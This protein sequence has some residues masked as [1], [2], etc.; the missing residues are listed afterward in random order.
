M[1]GRCCKPDSL[2]DHLHHKRARK[3]RTKRFVDNCKFC[4]S[5]A[6]LDD[7]L[8]EERLEALGHFTLLHGGNVLDGGSRRGEPMQS[9][10][11]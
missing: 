8:G 1:N 5:L 3:T 11:L 4:L 6:L 7:L 9:L 10:E 2:K